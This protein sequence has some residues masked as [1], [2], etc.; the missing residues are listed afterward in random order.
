[1]SEA[2]KPFVRLAGKDGNALAIL[3]ACG[4][5][6]R[7]AKWKESKVTK[8][9]AEMRAGDYVHLLRTAKKHF[10]VG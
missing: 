6:A 3:A 5:A 7:E 10:D 8:V 1:M 4:R 9:M 2:T